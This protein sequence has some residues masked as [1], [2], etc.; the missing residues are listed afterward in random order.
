MKNF[1]DKKEQ[2]SLIECNMA[3]AKKETIDLD[4]EF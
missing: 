2:N 1:F 4:L 3:K